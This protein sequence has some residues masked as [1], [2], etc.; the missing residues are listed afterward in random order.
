MGKLDVNVEVSARHVH[1]SQADI[2]TLFGEGYELKEKKK[3]AGGFVAEERL[4]IT[5]PKRSMER[6]AILGPA[7][8][9]TQVEISATDARSLGVNAPI[10]LSGKL[11][12][13][14]G[15]KITAANGKSIEIDHGAMVAKRHVHLSE[16]D[17]KTLGVEQNQVVSLKIDTGLGR[18][19]TFGDVV[20][21]IGGGVSVVHLDTDE[22]NAACVGRDCKGTIIA[23]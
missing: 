12:G 20:C 22:G 9:E 2:E 21:R 17:A 3:I 6:V 16:E 11:D 8:K 1:L 19:L 18:A 4:T 5:G 23:E 7:R 13:T 14:P 15:L 10:R